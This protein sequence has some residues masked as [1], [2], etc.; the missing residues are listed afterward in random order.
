M[1]SFQV[2]H[3][4]D[5]GVALLSYICTVWDQYIKRMCS[6]MHYKNTL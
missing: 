3:I 6:L 2:I 5:E 4:P 1:Q